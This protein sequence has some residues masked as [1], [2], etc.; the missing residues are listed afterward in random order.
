MLV[1]QTLNIAA[2]ETGDEN[3]VLTD[4]PL[5]NESILLLADFQLALPDTQEIL[6]EK[7]VKK[8]TIPGR[9]VKVGL[10]GND[11]KLNVIFTLYPADEGRLLLV[12]RSE[13]WVSGDYSSSLTS[14]ALKYRDQVYY[15]PLGRAIDSSDEKPVE[16]LVKIEIIPYLETLDDKSRTELE[17]VLGSSVRF[18]LVED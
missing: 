1:F 17:A 10:E 4:I 6:W 8:I 2:Q 15:Y 12:A 3:P 7:V 5:L 9:S 18:K 11:A 13:A 16:I 14:L